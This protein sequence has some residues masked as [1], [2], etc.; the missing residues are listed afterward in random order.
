MSKPVLLMS[1]S[2]EVK[3]CPQIR[4]ELSQ[5]EVRVWL[6]PPHAKVTP[7]KEISQ[8][9]LESKDKTRCSEL[10]HRAFSATIGPE[11]CLYSKVIHPF[12]WPWDFGPTVKTGTQWMSKL[13]IASL[14]G[15]WLESLQ[16]ALEQRQSKTSA[17]YQ[18]A[19]L[20]SQMGAPGSLNEKYPPWASI[21]KHLV[22]CQWLCLGRL[23]NLLEVQPCQR[24]LN[25]EEE[26]WKFIAL[27]LFRFTL[28]VSFLWT[29]VCSLSFQLQPTICCHDSPTI[30]DLPSGPVNQNKAF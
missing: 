11:W 12:W 30:M 17:Q 18:R 2:T 24:K 27:P 9:S 28:S 8:A 5:D 26:L 16:R 19:T 6:L 25:T 7:E 23:W 1:A 14:P 13:S 3:I 29:K 20:S 21:L 22:S 4:T 15:L 10:I